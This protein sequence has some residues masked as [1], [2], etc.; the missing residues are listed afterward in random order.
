[1]VPK[2]VDIGPDHEFDAGM[3]AVARRQ[4]ERMRM[5]E[6]EL[7]GAHPSDVDPDAE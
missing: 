4:V 5:M 3:V 1:M 6:W 7:T 2:A